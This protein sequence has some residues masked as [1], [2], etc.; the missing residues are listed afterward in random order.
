MLKMMMTM[1]SAMMVMMHENDDND[2][3]EQEELLCVFFNPSGTGSK[4]ITSTNFNHIQLTT[5][6]FIW[7]HTQMMHV[8]K[9]TGAQPQPV[10]QRLRP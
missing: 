9:R 7:V 2:D 10:L 4:S 5:L 3:D 6:T 1:M 8:H